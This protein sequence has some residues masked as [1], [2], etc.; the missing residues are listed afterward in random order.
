M[1]LPVLPGLAAGWK[2]GQTPVSPPSPPSLPDWAPIFA[3][4]GAAAAKCPGD[5]QTW[6]CTSSEW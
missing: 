1:P 2:C 4:H 5:R 3:H 6:S